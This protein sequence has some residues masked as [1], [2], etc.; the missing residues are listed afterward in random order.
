MENNNDILRHHGILG[1]KWGVRRYQNE[2]GT[3]T[4]IG[5]KR[6]SKGKT[7]KADREI[8]NAP[9]KNLR[10]ITKKSSDEMTDDELKEAI[11]RLRLEKTYKDLK[12]ELTPEVRKKA[13][14]ILKNVAEKS[15][16]NVG[17]QLFTYKL[18]EGINKLAEK[19][20][21]KAGVDSYAVVNPFKGQKRDDDKP[22]EGP[23]TSYGIMTKRI[24]AEEATKKKKKDDD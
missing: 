21:K 2:D 5:S 16:N 17:E 18:A 6:Y 8:K 11:E 3:L 24:A 20:Q 10:S 4:K 12:K 9:T 15:I 19:Q 22:W 13:E 23:S 1:Q 14:G 7:I